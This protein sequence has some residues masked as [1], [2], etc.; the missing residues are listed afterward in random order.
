MKLSRRVL[1]ATRA[2]G[3]TAG[4]PTTLSHLSGMIGLV[5]CPVVMWMLLLTLLSLANRIA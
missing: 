3:P 2:E 5:W 1:P 4:M